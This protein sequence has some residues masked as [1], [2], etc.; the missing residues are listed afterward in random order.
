MKA[1]QELITAKAQLEVKIQQIDHRLDDVIASDENGNIKT[2][3]RL[4]LIESK[5]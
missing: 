4:E 1:N 5:I 2:N 3:E